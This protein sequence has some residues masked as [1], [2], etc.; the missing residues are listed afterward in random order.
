MEQLEYGELPPI[1]VN[2]KGI[3]LA[4]DQSLANSGWVVIDART[5]L[6]PVDRGTFSA[7]TALEG[8]EANL[9]RGEDIYDVFCNWLAHMRCDVLV[10]EMPAARNTVQRPESAL[11]AALSLRL[12]ARSVG[13]PYKMISAN[14]AKLVV[15][16]FSR[17]DKKR[18]RRT[19]LERY[20]HLTSMRM[21]EHVLDAYAL[22]LTHIHEPTGKSK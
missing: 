3:V 21:N 1:E 13:I 8:N 16:G 17:A 19:I 11:L 15:T 2:Y 6:D 18:V 10:H 12:A 20:P 5:S 14:R 9:K 7:S 4:V 22:A